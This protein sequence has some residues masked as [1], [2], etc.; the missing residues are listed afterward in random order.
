MVQAASP[1]GSLQG[2]QWQQL[3]DRL[4]HKTGRMIERIGS[5]SPHVAAADTGIYDDMRLDWWTSGFWPGL[6]WIMYDM[7]GQELY[8]KAAWEWDARIEQKMLQDNNF[9]HDVGF[10]FSPTAVM[11]YKLTGDEDGRRRG[12]AAA[13]FLAG[14]FNLAGRFLRAW[15]QDKTGWSIIDSAM[16]LSILFWAS[17][18]SGDPR[19]AHIAKAH[20]D[21]IIEHFIREDGSV[22]H[23]VHF[24]PDTGDFVEA[25]GGQG[26]APDS[27]WS[28]GAAWAIHGLANVYRYTGDARY[29]HASQRAAHYFLSMLP[30]DDVPHWDFRASGQLDGEPR[31][32][33]AA[34]CAASGLIEL[35]EA[36]PAVQGRVYRDAAERIVSSL[37]AN[38]AAWDNETH[39]AILLEGTGNKPAGSNINV[40]LIYGDY[41]FVEAVAKLIGWHNRIF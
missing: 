7:T 11:K 34:A 25:L 14:R 15:N 22:R 6:L 23:I 9:H 5:K 37:A 35:A 41:F 40:S 1:N 38:Y 18:E 17:E 32:T 31:D 26:A 13:N 39:E 36:L 12:L 4:Q 21:T 28:R 30:A 19:F 10:Q 24:D 27:A 2:G 16:N 3:W 29:L 20:A 33:S 8:K